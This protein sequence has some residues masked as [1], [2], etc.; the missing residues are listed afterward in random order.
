MC[1][2]HVLSERV[3]PAGFYLSPIIE[4][5]PTIFPQHI[6]FSPLGLCTCYALSPVYFPLSSRF[7][8][9][10]FKTLLR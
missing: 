7:F 3:I 4:Q 10:S 8:L 9:T 1:A 6:T 5:I 2:H